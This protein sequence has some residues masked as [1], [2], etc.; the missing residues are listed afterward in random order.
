MNGRWTNWTKWTNWWRNPFLNLDLQIFS[1]S[2]CPKLA[3]HY[4]KI[5]SLSGMSRY[6]KFN[7]SNVATITRIPCHSPQTIFTIHSAIL[8]QWTDSKSTS[9]RTWFR[10]TTVSIISDLFHLWFCSAEWQ[11]KVIS[12]S[13]LEAFGYRPVCVKAVLANRLE[14]PKARCRYLAVDEDSEEE[15]LEWIE[16]Q[17]KKC[18]LVTCTDIKNYCEVKYSRSVSRWW[19]GSFVWRHR[20]DLTKTKS[21]FQENLRLE[22]SRVFLDE[23]IRC[24][25]QYVKGMKTELVFN[26]NEVAMSE[27]EDWKDKK[28]FIPR[29]LMIRRYII[30]HHK[31]WNTYR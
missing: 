30:A 11:S 23:T 6:P 31:M 7:T 16:I 22:V 9:A 19:V 12:Q 25:R 10:R 29:R 15:I 18:K 8:F 26:L 3:S 13:T 5:L 27:W 14:E 20:D 1:D 21:T 17:A 4:P 28:I 2:N 24:L